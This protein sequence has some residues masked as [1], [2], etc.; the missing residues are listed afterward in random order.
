MPPRSMLCH[1][2]PS[3]CCA[4]PCRAVPCSMACHAMLHA[5]HAKLDMLRMP[6]ALSLVLCLAVPHRAMLQ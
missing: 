6:I 2:V 3:L 1:A 4:V 5:L